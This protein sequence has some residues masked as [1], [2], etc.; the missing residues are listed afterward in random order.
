MPRIGLPIHKFPSSCSAEASCFISLFSC[1]PYL[2]FFPLFSPLLITLCSV[3]QPCPAL[4]SPMGCSPPRASV[5]GVLQA[6]TLERGAMPS[7]RGLPYPGTE[8]AAPAFAGGF[9]PV[10]PPG[11]PLH[12]EK[13]VAEEASTIK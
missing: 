13:Q 6:R 2:S 7:S 3:T 11:K 9:F 5:R 10:V 8:P 4:C 1:G 12:G